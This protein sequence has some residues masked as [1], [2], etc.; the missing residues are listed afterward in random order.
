[1]NTENIKN[2]TEKVDEGTVKGSELDAA[3]AEAKD[4]G[5]YTH[6]FKKPFVWEGKEFKVLHF[7]FGSLTGKDMM[8]IEKEI[9]ITEGM[10]ILSP[11]MSGVFVLYMAAKAA[12][13]GYDALMG[14]PINEVNTIRTKARNFL[15]ASEL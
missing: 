4:V 1:M 6:R 9:S 7:D 10:T 8:S 12:G 13:I 3:I 5:G 11:G 2:E 14:M 15:L